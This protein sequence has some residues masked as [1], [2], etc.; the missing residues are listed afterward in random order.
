MRLFRHGIFGLFASAKAAYVQWQPCAGATEVFPDGFPGF[1]AQSLS[2]GLSPSHDGSRPGK[3]TSMEFKIGA[4]IGEARCASFVEGL[5]PVRVDFQ[6]LGRTEIFD[7]Q[8]TRATCAA[9]RSSSRA[10]L[11]IEANVDIEE[12]P[13]LSTFYLTLHTESQARMDGPADKGCLAAAITPAITPDMATGLRYGQTALFLFVF[14]VSILRTIY[15]TEPATYSDDNDDDE[16]E[17]AVPSAARPTRALLPGLGEL[18]HYLQFIFLSA[19]LSLR[20]PGFFQPIASYLNWFSLFSS[21]GPVGHA[22]R[23]TSIN[24]GIYERNGTYGGTFGLELMTQ[25]VGAPTPWNITG[26]VVLAGVV[27]RRLYLWNPEPNE[28]GIKDA[29]FTTGQVFRAIFSYFSIPLVALST[30]QFDYATLLPAYHTAMAATLLALI[31]LAFIW[32]LRQIPARSLGALVFN[33]PKYS[34]L[35]NP[36]GHKPGPQTSF[37]VIMFVLNFIRGIAI[38]GLQISGVAQLTILLACEVVFVA[39]IYSFN[40]HRL[41]SACVAC[42][43]ARAVVIAVMT[44][45][46]PG[47]ASSSFGQVYSVRQLRRREAS[48][49]NLSAL[50]TSSSLAALGV[51]DVNLQPTLRPDTPSTLRLDTRSTSSRFYR[52]P[53]STLPSTPVDLQ[54]NKIASPRPSSSVALRPSYHLLIIAAKLSFFLLTRGW[55]SHRLSAYWARAAV[56]RLHFPRIR[57]LLHAAP[58]SRHANKGFAKHGRCYS[59][60]AIFAE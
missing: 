39:S 48:R 1:L 40:T 10:P 32:L 9:A 30:Y 12:L 28:N 16:E 18:L 22:K 47:V 58:T 36:A 60:S 53:R 7:A 2:A 42:T 17:A 50:V 14:I 49:A 4:Q 26:L 43:I 54:D 25:I 6:I 19:S 20:Y 3:S 37:V 59:G 11:T 31:A 35:H 21:E 41:F 52:P 46:L 56:E 55:K 15:D 57:S 24:D 34:P 8:V 51:S 29:K 38:G 45:Y 23:Y 13:L 5:K 27:N 44:V 33:A